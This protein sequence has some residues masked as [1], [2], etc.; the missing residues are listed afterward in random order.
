VVLERGQLL[1]AA[2][3]AG[4]VDD[5]AGGDEGEL[6]PGGGVLGEGETGE[7]E[8]GVALMEGEAAAGGGVEGFVEGFA[9]DVEGAGVGMEGG[10]GEEAEGEVVL[11]AG[12]TEAVDRGGELAGGLGEVTGGATLDGEEIRRDPGRAGRGRCRGA[13]LFAGHPPR[14]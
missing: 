14:H 7:A 12:S 2:V 3:V 13:S 9:G 6:S 1:V 5:L 4:L 10:A 11:P 8:G